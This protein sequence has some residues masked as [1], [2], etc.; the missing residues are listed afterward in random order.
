MSTHRSRRP[1]TA[2]GFVLDTSELGR[3]PGSM[4]AE[5]RVVP[6]PRRI[7]AEMVAIDEGADIDL[8]LRL[9]AVS[10]GVLVTGTV[11]AD[12]TGE[13]S[14]CLEPFEGNVSLPVTELFAYRDSETEATT[15]EGEVYLV[16]DDTI[17]LEPVIVDAVG[18]ALPFQPLCSEDCLGL[19]PECG[20]RLAIAEPGHGHDILDPRW[21][22]LAAKFG[23]DAAAGSDAGDKNDSNP[24]E[25]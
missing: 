10:E 22:G 23:L 8:D 17:D 2:A 24:E 14:R 9:E 20:V 7:G 16:E 19:C 4:R 1:E 3:R 13:C 25:K 21:A 12:T 5:H 11:E 15:E 18:L 6:S